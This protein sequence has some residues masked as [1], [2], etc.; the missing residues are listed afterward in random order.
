MTEPDKP[1]IDTLMLIDD[2]EVDL[3]I[4]DRI[5]KRSGWWA[6]R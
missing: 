1:I 6:I 4:Y 3:L 2:S 5:I